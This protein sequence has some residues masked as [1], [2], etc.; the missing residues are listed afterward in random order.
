MPTFEDLRRTLARIDGRGYKAYKD[1][2]GSYHHHQFVLFVDHVQGDPYAYPSKVRV[3]VSQSIANVPQA[4]FANTVRR[5]A[6]QDFLIRTTHSAIRHVS[7][8]HR[9]IG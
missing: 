2:E 9:G 7:Q 6:V 8:G 4:F 3:R 1:L 5:V